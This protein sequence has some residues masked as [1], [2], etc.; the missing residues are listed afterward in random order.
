MH[1][2]AGW[3]IELYVDAAT[4]GSSVGRLLALPAVS[5]DHLGLSQ[6]GVPTLLRLAEGGV[7]V[8]ATGFGRVDFDVRP[9]LRELY[10]SNPDALMFG[11]DLPSTRAGTAFS[12]DDLAQVLAE[13]DDV[14]AGKVLYENAMRFYRMAVDVAAAGADTAR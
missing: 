9:V 4:L 7:R 3:H 5:I 2:I 11:T 10:S 1:A 6:A 12:D 14:Q 8:K 13:F